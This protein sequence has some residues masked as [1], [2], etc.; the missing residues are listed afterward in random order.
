MS[1]TSHSI[2]FYPSR[3]ITN[4]TRSVIIY[5]FGFRLD[6]QRPFCVR[7][8]CRQTVTRFDSQFSHILSSVPML[9]VIYFAILQQYDSISV[10]FA[11]SIIYVVWHQLVSKCSLIVHWHVWWLGYLRRVFHLSLGLFSPPR[12]ASKL[13]VKHQ[14]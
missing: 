7:L 6:I 2:K 14:T 8:W 12:A 9:Y 1:S 4:N 5:R 11:E 3:F 13:A 10:T